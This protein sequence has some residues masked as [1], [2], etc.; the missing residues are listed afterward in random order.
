MADKDQPGLLE[1]FATARPSNPLFCH[2]EFLEKLAEHS[3]GSIGRRATFIMQRLAVDARRLHYKATYGVNRGWRRSRLGG[4]RGSHFY[5]WWAPKNAIPLKEADAFSEAPDGALFLRDI[6]HH[7]DHSALAPHAHQSHYLPV[8]VRDLRREEYGPAPWTQPQARF[9]TARQPVRLLKGH[10]G[11][12]KTTALWHAADS[13]GAERVLYVTYSRDLAALALDYF[14]RY[15]SSHKRFHVLTFPTLIRQL[16]GSSAPIGA[17]SEG[18]QRFLRDLYPFVRTLGAWTNSQV[19]LYDEFHAHLVGDALPVAIGRFTASKQPRVSNESYRERRTR[20][21]GLQAA[22]AALETA[23]RLERADSS[24]LADRY[25]PELALAWQAA[26]RLRAGAYGGSRPGTELLD[27]DCIAVDESQDLTPIEAFVLVQLA[28]RIRQR[29]VPV[30]LLM[31]GDEAQTVRPTDFEW[32]WLSDLLHSHVGTPSEHKLSSNL[33]SPRRIADLVNRV[34]DLYSRIEKQERPS[35]TGYAEIDDDAT[36]QILYCTAVPGPELNTLLSALAARE[37]LALIAVGD[38]VPAFIPESVRPAVLT[39]S[40]AKGLDFHSVCVIDAGRLMDRIIHEEARV[41]AGSDIEGLRK[42]LAIDQL[43]VA[44]SRPSER[45]LWLDINPSD[46]IVRQ[47]VAFLN[48]GSTGGEIS[49]CVPAA[50]LKTLEEDELDAEERVQRC[51]ADARQYLEVKPEMAWSRAQQAVT[52]LGPPGSP[53]AVT[54]QTARDTAYL[55][56]AEICFILALRN[57]R[58]A[59]ELGRPDLFGEAR[60]AASTARRHGLAAIIRAIES[61][62]RASSENRLAALAQLAHELPMYRGDIEPWLQLELGAKSREWVEALEN[63]LFSGRNAAILIKLL[64]P[65]YEA[66]GLPDRTARMQRLQQRA[67]QLLIKEKQFGPA[68]AALRAVPERQP[69]LEA[70]CHEG[71]GDLL[72]AA[73]CHR[74]AGNVK[75]ALNCYRSVPDL[76]AALNLLREM[77]EHPATQSLEWMAKLQALVAERPEKFTKVV[78]PAE[79]KF[80]EELLERSLGVKRRKPTPRVPRKRAPSVLL[81][82]LDKIYAQYGTK[83]QPSGIQMMNCELGR[84]YRSAKAQSVYLTPLG[85]DRFLI[86]LHASAPPATAFLFQVF[87]EDYTRHAEPAPKGFDPSPV[88]KSSAKRWYRKDFDRSQEDAIVATVGAVIE[89]ATAR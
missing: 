3:N 58:L 61:V 59:P 41:R 33:R 31:A 32:G 85:V 81:P 83:L 15:C 53:A 36:D 18:Q 80:L 62:H 74:A 56:L 65:F 25:F 69:K 86:E 7:D 76:E 20:F 16:L 6:R 37:G 71:L 42:R 79:K 54:D 43:R 72:G 28:L 8:T 66:L 77:G 73:E 11:S 5:A 38:A 50:V 19:A 14:D 26:E 64:P 78:T 52:L 45:L 44:L 39:V 30:S 9:A 21:L 27:F 34:W 67:I 4:N 13:S 68:L 70:V 47:S 48:A 17:E 2:Q 55:T 84:I 46:K 35:G 63:A 24:A 29:R 57:A 22:T 1:I 10:P 23:A 87:T 49:S 60:N 51:Q 12:G 89:F 82:I 40:Q 75:E 88:L